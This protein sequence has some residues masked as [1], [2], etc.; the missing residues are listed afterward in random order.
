M[1]STFIDLPDDVATS[2][3]QISGG[4]ISDLSPV[5]KVILAVILFGVVLAFLIGSFRHH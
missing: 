1:L 3:L 2:T 4:L 5:W